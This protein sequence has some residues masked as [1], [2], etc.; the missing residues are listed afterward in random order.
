MK[1]VFLRLC[2]MIIFI[3]DF[4]A[5]NLTC[6]DLKTILITASQSEKYSS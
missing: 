4:S 5:N 1:P 3:T 2:L 6:M